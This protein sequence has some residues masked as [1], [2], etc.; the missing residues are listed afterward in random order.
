MPIEQSPKGGPLIF[1][2]T[3]A[4]CFVP[5]F[6]FARGAAFW[7]G[8]SGI[9]AVLVGF[10]MAVDKSYKVIL[11]ADLRSS[12]ISKMISG[13]LSAGVLYFI[14]SV[15]GLASKELF[16]FAAGDIS[17]IYGFSEG[18]PVGRIVLLIFLI[19]GPGEELFWRG[20]LQRAWQEA[21]GGKAGWLL[22]SAL[23]ALVHAGSGNAFLVLAAAVCGLFWGYIYLRA[24]SVV[25]TAISHTL[26][27]L[28][29]FVAFPLH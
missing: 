21:L 19:I 27:D 20:Y 13:A 1:S 26:W 15:G 11:S 14:F 23:Y 5:L 4:A 18:T 12:L 3:A 7:W 25:L 6:I 24:K 29:V 28:L 17:R 10:T 9:I 2:L 8:I 16:S 22:T